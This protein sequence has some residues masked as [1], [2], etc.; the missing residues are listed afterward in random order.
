MSKVINNDNHPDDKGL[1]ATQED[2]WGTVKDTYPNGFR[3]MQIGDYAMPQ[4]GKPSE[5][6]KPTKDRR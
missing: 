6:D 1:N 2:H 3:T 5:Y 4:M